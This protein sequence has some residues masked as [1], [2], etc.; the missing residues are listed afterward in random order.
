MNRDGANKVPVTVAIG[1]FLL[2]K[3]SYGYRSVQANTV[4]VP[5]GDR[6]I[7]GRRVFD[8]LGP[9]KKIALSAFTFKLYLNSG[10]HR[11]MPPPDCNCYLAGAVRF[12]PISSKN[13]RLNKH[14]PKSI[15]REK[16]APSL[17][18]QTSD[19]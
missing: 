2:R 11:P 8:H 3:K 16:F 12:W 13:R 14:C 4:Q 6:T 18:N 7:P 1:R 17:G 5:F 15:V 19:P 10:T 9:E